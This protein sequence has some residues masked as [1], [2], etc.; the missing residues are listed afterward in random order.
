MVLLL[1]PL[2]ALMIPLVAYG[3][4]GLHREQSGGFVGFLEQQVGVFVRDL[5]RMPPL[6]AVV[7]LARWL[8]HHVSS[9]FLNTQKPL[10][11]WLQ[12]MALY[13]SAL[14]EIAFNQPLR[15]LHTAY[16]LVYREIPLQVRAAVQP[17]VRAERALQH[18]L[19]THTKTIVKI[20]R[21][22]PAIAH[23]VAVDTIPKVA[24]PHVQEWEWLHKHWRALVAAV[25]GAGVLGLPGTTG[26]EG[27]IDAIKKRLKKL[28]KVG[29]GAAAVGI[30][31]VAL[32]R[33][34]LG[35][36]RCN[37]TDKALKRL[38]G[39]DPNLLESILADTLAVFGTISIVEFAE[40]MQKLAPGVQWGLGHLIR[41]APAAFTDVPEKA[42]QDAL[43]LLPGF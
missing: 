3:L 2:A 33:L 21:A 42:L 16:W 23:R 17:L 39:L 37:N 13:V 7:A 15:A 4:S 5:A 29:L 22:A 32:N 9:V 18:E 1:L 6:N 38:C 12:G 27:S 40:G 31:G 11:S 28:E 36:A 8:S 10:T 30:V 41:E 19:L 20:E 43:S 24:I 14:Q 34:G 26:L 25:A 35:R